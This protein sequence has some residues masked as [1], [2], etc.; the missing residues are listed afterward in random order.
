MMDKDEFREN[1]CSKS[2][3][4]FV[5]KK[6]VFLSRLFIFLLMTFGKCGAWKNE[7]FL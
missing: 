7:L 1:W 2:R 6:N 3:I 4:L 5:R